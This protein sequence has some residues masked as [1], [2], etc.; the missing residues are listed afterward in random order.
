MVSLSLS[1]LL[2]L[3]TR[4]SV[5]IRGMSLWLKIWTRLILIILSKLRKLL[6]FHNSKM[7]WGKEIIF[8][9]IP[10]SLALV[11]LAKCSPG[12]KAISDC[13]TIHF[14]Y[15]YNT[16]PLDGTSTLAPNHLLRCYNWLKV[17]NKHPR[18]SYTINNHCLWKN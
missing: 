7:Y 3:A 16:I 13:P 11:P 5:H 18:W 8:I 9:F 1:V 17:L 2:T 14:G 12:F 6:T 10:V 4:P 15:N